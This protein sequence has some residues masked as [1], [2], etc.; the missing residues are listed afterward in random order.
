[1]LHAQPRNPPRR[2]PDRDDK[3]W[4]KP[5]RALPLLVLTLTVAA[6]ITAAPDAAAAPQCGKERWAVKTGTDP[7][8]GWY[9]GEEVN[10]YPSDRQRRRGDD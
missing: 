5:S 4:M 6:A 3:R 10:Q 2:T 1:M 9:T 7:F 8:T